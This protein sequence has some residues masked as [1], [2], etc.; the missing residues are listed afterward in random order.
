MTPLTN[1]HRDTTLFSRRQMLQTAAAVAGGSLLTGFLPGSAMAR[2][3]AGA[4]L[5]QAGAAPADPIAAM[6]AQMGAAPIVPTKLADNLT[7][8]SGP[9]GNVVVLNGPDGKVVVDSFVQPAWPKLKQI[10]DGMEQPGRSN[11]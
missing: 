8:L 1:S 2:A 6:R 7:L 4:L 9:G 5:P 11:C 3:A 10:L